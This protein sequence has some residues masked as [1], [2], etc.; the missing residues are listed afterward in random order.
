MSL[1]DHAISHVV[2]GDGCR[3][4]YRLDGPREAPVLLFANSLGSRLEVWDAQAAA[5]AGPYRVLRYDGRGHGRSDA[6]AGAYGLDRLGR[7][8]VALLDALEIE[9]AHVCGLSLGGVIGQWL[10]FRAPERLRSL[11]LANTAAFM[12]PPDPWE[13]RIAA[14]RSGGMAALTESVLARWFTPA[15]LASAPDRVAAVREM[16]LG[17]PA[18]GYAGCCAAIRDMDLRPTAP[19]IRTPVSVIVGAHDPSTPPAEGRWLAEAIPEA[20][21]V[22]LD[23]A[24]LSNVEQAGAF[25]A[26][27]AAHL[28]ALP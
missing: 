12:G 16:L 15:F 5:F 24:H 28:D 3:L 17:T 13:G 26:A 2:L 20:R 6:P 8:A 10:G 27:L 7:D 11:V 4:A 1:N 18:A 25:T 21:L 23:S 22:T 9:R 14:V 19:L